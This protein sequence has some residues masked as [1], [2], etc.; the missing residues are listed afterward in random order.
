MKLAPDETTGRTVIDRMIY[1]GDVRPQRLPLTASALRALPIGR[2]E[3]AINKADLPADLFSDERRDDGFGVQFA[4]VDAELAAYLDETEHRWMSWSR[5]Q[6]T[7]P[8]REPLSRPDGTDPDA[9]SRRVAQAYAVAV[10]STS[11]PAKALAD[12]AQ[13]PVTTV[14]RW[15]RE[16]RQRGHL[17]PARRGR[18]G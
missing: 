16:A 3:A 2:I 8:A 14:H 9:F 5:S 6:P 4:P 15:I 13:V 18:A 1:V 11:A 10:E 7:T 17:P 12:E